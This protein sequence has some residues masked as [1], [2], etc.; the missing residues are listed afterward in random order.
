M[1]YMKMYDLNA[2]SL[3]YMF[4]LLMDYTSAWVI[5]RDTCYTSSDFESSVF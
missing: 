5:G 2:M 4:T 3:N 1:Q